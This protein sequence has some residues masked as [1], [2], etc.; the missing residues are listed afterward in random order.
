M[1]V[2]N[3]KN[4]KSLDKI[5]IT[6]GNEDL[7][8]IDNAIE[9][10]LFVAGDAVKLSD[11][12][13]ALEE[14]VLT[15]SGVIDDMI[16]KSNEEVSG[17][18]VRR[19]GDKV[20]KGDVMDAVVVRTK[21]GVRRSDGSLIRFDGNAAVILSNQKEPIGSRI[22]GPVTRELREKFMQIISLAP[23]VL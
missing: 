2:N 11:I 1:E 13:M 3:E 20:Q 17:I 22:F 18:Q 5:F 21:Q 12:A 7:E 10:I 4:I 15:V 16:E 19:L 8:N 23:E 14:S 6:R 9:A